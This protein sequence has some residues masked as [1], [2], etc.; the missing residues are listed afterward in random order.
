MSY[1]WIHTIQELGDLKGPIAS[2]QMSG[3]GATQNPNSAQV[4]KPTH[5]SAFNR[6]PKSQRFQYI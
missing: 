5:C 2:L 1:G 6:P 4:W 3:D